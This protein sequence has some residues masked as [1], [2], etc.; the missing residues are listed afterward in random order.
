MKII[1]KAAIVLFLVLIAGC[2]SVADIIDS[3][4]PTQVDPIITRIAPTA[5]SAGDTVTVFGVGF[6]AAAPLNIVVIEGTE[7]A[8]NA[9]TLLA[10]PVGNEVESITFVVPVGIAVGTRSIYV[11]VADN[12]SNA[13]LSITINP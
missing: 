2:G 1:S 6:S 12:P 4:V 9:Y 13:N 7:V 8:A 3:T 5:A 11:V 10:A